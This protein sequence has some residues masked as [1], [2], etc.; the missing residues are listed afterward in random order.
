MSSEAAFK[1]AKLRQLKTTLSI[2]NRVLHSS[3]WTSI[4]Y[5]VKMNH[6]W[7]NVTI[8]QTFE[9]KCPKV[10]LAGKYFV[11]ITVSMSRL[12][13]PNIRLDSHLGPRRR[14]VA[15]MR[16]C[17]RRARAAWTAGQPGSSAGRCG[18]YAR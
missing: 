10:L 3:I 8:A 12:R 18:H 16:G 7:R 11:S 6:E 4:L 5:C 14:A 1:G 2:Y 15:G 13:S 9:D 17:P